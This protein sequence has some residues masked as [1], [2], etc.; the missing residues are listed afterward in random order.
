[1]FDC[2]KHKSTSVRSGVIRRALCRRFYFRPWPWHSSRRWPILAPPYWRGRRALFRRTP[3]TEVGPSIPFFGRSPHV[4][5]DAPGLRKCRAIG[6]SVTILRRLQFVQNT[7]A[8]LIF[9]LHRAGHLINDP[10]CLHWLHVPQ[11]VQFKMAVLTNRASHGSKRPYLCTFTPVS[12]LPTRRGLHSADSLWLVVPRICLSTIGDRAFPV[13]SF[14][15]VYQLTSPHLLHL[16]SSAPAKTLTYLVFHF[17]VQLFIAVD[18][19]LAVIQLCACTL[20]YLVASPSF[21]MNVV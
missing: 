2:A 9:G 6:L 11:R 19:H 5:D 17:L 16:A 4:G 8:R 14:V 15:T 18:S 10:I 21:C 1:V 12:W 7:A 13:P 3:A 20:S